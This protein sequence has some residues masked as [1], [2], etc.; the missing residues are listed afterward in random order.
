MIFIKSS[1]RFMSLSIKQAL[2][3]K[4][5]TLRSS[6]VRVAIIH[7]IKKIYLRHDFLNRLNDVCRRMH[8]PH[9]VGGSKHHCHVTKVF[10][11]VGDGLW[12]RRSSSHL[13]CTPR[14]FP[15]LQS[16][17]KKKF[18]KDCIRIVLAHICKT[19]VFHLHWEKL[20]AF[21]P[22]FPGVP[23]LNY[24]LTCLRF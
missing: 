6:R 23:C 11:K 8:H 1:C 13:Q 2:Q 18:Y 9:Q 4:P 24:V 22:S 12:V 3:Q 14:L 16:I 21:P 7:I 5:I 20:W 10:P 15:H 17:I 19:F